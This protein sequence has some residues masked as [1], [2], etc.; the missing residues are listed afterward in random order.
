MFRGWLCSPAARSTNAGLVEIVKARHLEM[1]EPLLRV[2]I[3]AGCEASSLLIQRR[4]SLI[5]SGPC[6]VARLD[7]YRPRD[8]SMEARQYSRAAFD[9]PAARRK[10]VFDVRD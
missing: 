2:A 1:V 4:P 7:L 3:V 6:P 5:Q 9:L 10:R 8:D